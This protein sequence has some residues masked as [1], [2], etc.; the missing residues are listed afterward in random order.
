MNP[1]FVFLICAYLL[2]ACE[3]NKT[4]KSIEKSPTPSVQ[5][6][7]GSTNIQTH[8]DLVDVQQAHSEIQIELKYTTSANFLGEKLYSK[9]DK[10]YLQ[11]D[12]A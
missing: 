8:P 9:I 12:V 4:Q 5:D 6:H 7:T 3:N 10:A 11:K 1:V 2:C